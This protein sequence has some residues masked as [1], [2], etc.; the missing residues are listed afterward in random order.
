[1]KYPFREIS[2]NEIE[3]VKIGNAENTEYATGCTVII[4][5]NG[6]PAGMDVRGGGPASRESELL[7]ASASAEVIHAVLL[8]GGSAFG[9]DAAG[10][11]MEYLAEKGIG[12][13]LGDI[14]VPLVC[15]SCIFDLAFVSDRVKPDK[16][17]ARK[18]CENAELNEPKQG[19]VGAGT[20]ATVGK[21]CE[22]ERIMNSGLG[23]YALQLGELK[24]GAVVAVNAMGD[25]YDFETGKVLAGMRTKD[26]KSIDDSEAALYDM[27]LRDPVYSAPN[28]NTTIGAVITNARFDKARLNKIASMAQNGLARSIRPVHTLSDGDTVYA[29]STGDVAADV[30]VVGTLAS[31]VMAAAIRNAVLNC[32]SFHGVPGASDMKNI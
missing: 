8:S 3:N 9:L 28:S 27:Y 12:F 20:G 32:G 16:A 4:C 25:V 10:G 14:R 15:Q 31:H 24:V 7:N 1:M 19:N 5:E 30:N 13:A 11:V 29:L 17:M 22:P 26:G 23:I 2:I 21:F 18:A 6:M